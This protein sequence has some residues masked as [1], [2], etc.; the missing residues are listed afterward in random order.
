L[1]RLL[2][3]P[4][5]YA[6][7][8]ASSILGLAQYQDASL[9]HTSLKILA[10]ESEPETKPGSAAFFLKLVVVLCLV[11]VG[12]ALAGLTLALMSQ[13]AINLEVMSNAGDEKER[14]RAGKV[15]KL[16]KK[17]QHWVLGTHL[18]FICS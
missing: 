10:E 8:A 11:L 5:A 3:L 17:G 4:L 16:I 15:L 14:H 9:Y 6:L 2:K 7:P 12:G 18:Y 1:L 13:D